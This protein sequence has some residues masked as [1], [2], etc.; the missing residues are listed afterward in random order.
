MAVGK[1]VTE[2]WPTGVTR[3]WPSWVVTAL[4]NALGPVRV[5]AFDSAGKVTTCGTLRIGSF[6]RA[7]RVVAAI[8]K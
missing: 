3:P 2:T 6:T 4:Q 1:L 5:P 8:G 7:A